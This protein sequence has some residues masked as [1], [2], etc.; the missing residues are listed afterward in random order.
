MDNKQFFQANFKAIKQ[1]EK[2]TLIRGYASTP[3][4]DRH[5]DVVEPD[6]FR[7][8]IGGNFAKNPIVLF[9]HNSDRPI[10]KVN[11]MTID[12]KGL[13]VEIVIVDNEI[14]P[15]VNAG[16]LQTLSIGYIPTKIEFRDRDN[17]LI[18][19][20]TDEGKQR[21]WFEKGVKRIIKEL[22]LFE[23]SVV[24][25]PANPDATFAPKLYNLAKSV[26]NFFEI[27][28]K[29][30][31]STN[32]ND[33]TKNDKS[34]DLLK[35]DDEE[36]VVD[37]SENV[38][39]P[40]EEA[41]DTS[42]EEVESPADETSG[43]DEA[44]EKDDADESEEAEDKGDSE[45]D[46]EAEEEAESED[47]EGEEGAEKAEEPEAEAEEDAEEGDDS[48]DAEE[49]PAEDAEAEPEGDDAEGDDD[50]EKDFDIADELVTKENLIES[51][52]E[53]VALK[54]AN[55]R[56][57]ER[58]KIAEGKLPAKKALS[59]ATGIAGVKAK[60]DPKKENEEPVDD[61]KGFKGGF[62]GAK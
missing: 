35:K 5:N 59:F 2:G 10:G 19:Q 13:N 42:K 24:S 11:A 53:V 7:K 25:I 57:A 29:E 60:T 47:D 37:E 54:Q 3:T 30:F 55:K 8:T 27:Q 9:Q 43:D 23:I 18:D 15:K 40:Q 49:E 45:D 41:D 39:N 34:I 51:R 48:E 58:V 61:K 28:K 56:L 44:V 17:E 12:P 38:E 46:A 22:E 20:N 21:I 6:A 16:I 4:H 52:K 1:T 32:K 36:N 26:K 31:L 33:M 50:G 14:E 62:F